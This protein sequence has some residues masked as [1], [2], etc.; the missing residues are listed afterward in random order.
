[1]VYWRV[2]S[3]TR[4]FVTGLNSLSTFKR[5]HAPL[6]SFQVMRPCVPREPGTWGLLARLRLKRVPKSYRALLTSIGA[7]E[8]CFVRGTV[9]HVGDEG[10]GQMRNAP[11][12]R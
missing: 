4:R 6:E 11:L 2:S 10:K 5:L 7:A 12:G 1:M 8:A 9:D 3:G